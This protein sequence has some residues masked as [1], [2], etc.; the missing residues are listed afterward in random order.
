M[1][2]YFESL[3]A[4]FI[5]YQFSSFTSK[6]V[7]EKINY[8]LAKEGKISLENYTTIKYVSNMLRQFYTMRFL[9]RKGLK[10]C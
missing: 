5:M 9:R 8:A 10:E 2:N 7:T 4:L 3:F 1:T 6:S